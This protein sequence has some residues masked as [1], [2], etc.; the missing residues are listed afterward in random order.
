MQNV[1]PFSF[2]II[3]PSYDLTGRWAIRCLKSIDI[4]K[5]DVP[6]T[7]CLIDDASPT[8]GKATEQFC[9][10]RGWQYIRRAQRRGALAAA[11]L[12]IESLCPFDED[13]IVNI[14]GDDWFSSHKALDRIA[15]EYRSG[16]LATY[17]S[18]LLLHD[19]KLFQDDTSGAPPDKDGNYR[20]GDWHYPQPR[21]YKYKLLKRVRPEDLRNPSTGEYYFVG[22]DVAYMTPIMEMAG[23]RLRYIQDAIYGYTLDNP[24][25]VAG[26]G[27]AEQKTVREVVS[28]LPPYPAFEG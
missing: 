15:Q 22:C 26:K 18:M 1:P 16:A 19:G 23:S 9:R 28:K 17:G 20:A 25:R 4:Q 24:I 2:K 7:V 5:T 3:I 6:H 13:V 12:A 21:T 14:D 11:M 8:S 10:E 27:W